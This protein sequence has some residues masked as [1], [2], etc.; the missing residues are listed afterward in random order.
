MRVFIAQVTHQRKTQKTASQDEDTNS[1]VRFK[2]NQIL[3]L[4]SLD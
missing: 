1:S 3:L 4:F 2:V